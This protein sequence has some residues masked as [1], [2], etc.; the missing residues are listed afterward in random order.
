MT[1]AVC[2]VPGLCSLSPA[3]GSISSNLSCTVGSP[4]LQSQIYNPDTPRPLHSITLV[5]TRFTEM[6]FTKSTVLVHSIPVIKTYTVDQ[7]LKKNMYI[8]LHVCV[9]L[10]VC[11]CVSVSVC[12]CVSVCVSVFVCVSVSVSLYVCV[13]VCVSVCVCVC[14]FLCLCMC[15]CVFL[16]VCFCVC[17][18]VCFCVCFCVC[19][20]V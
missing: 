10:C 17:V 11:I 4:H 8:W 18:C 9:C 19:V 14:V 7:N 5:F 15:V 3:L 2:T 13:C 16:C 1:R 6:H 20:C 12:P